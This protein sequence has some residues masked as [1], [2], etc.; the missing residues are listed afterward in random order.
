MG[1]LAEVV[2]FLAIAVL[3]AALASRLGVL[4]PI[5]LVVLGL[6]LSFVPGFPQF[7]LHPDLVLGGILPPL[8]YIAA[9]ETSVPAFRFNL[10]PI[11]L[12][13][14]G[15]VLF[16]AFAVGVVTHALLPAVP[17][18]ACLAFGAVVA[19]PDAVAATAVA[20]RVGLPR[21]VVTVLEGESL[22]NDAT[23]LVLLRVSSAAALG[24]AVNVGDIAAEAI[25]AAGGGI[26]VGAVGALII[27]ALHARII[28]PLLDNALSL[29]TPF[30]LAL[31]AEAVTA[32]SVV[33]V[34]V[35]GLALGHRKPVLLSAASRLQMSSFWKL[36]KFLLEG[37]VFLLV[38]LQLRDVVDQLDPPWTTVATV[39][40]AV[41]G[42]VLIARFIW[43]YPATYLV[44]LV[45]RVRRRDPNPPVAVPTVVGWAGMRGVVTLAGALALPLTLADGAAYPRALFVWAALAVIMTT[46]LI[47]GTTLP[48]VARLLR[49]PP[50]DSTREA[51]MR[52]AVQHEASRAARD[53]LAELDDKV[54][55]DVAE[56]LRRRVD[57]RANFAWEQI[58]GGPESP[59][60]A[61]ARV[62]QE[63]I[64][65]ERM[66]F[67]TAR[68]DGRIP[69]EALVRAYRDLDLEESLLRGGKP[70]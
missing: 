64:D 14:V 20:R 56:R 61:Y 33:A 58:G 29:L 68:D 23:A 1:A 4:S 8:L 15:L 62:R 69:E 67:R 34:V 28:D 42:T 25:V 10:R 24:A 26:L 17:F 35:A 63:M 22:V 40:A 70:R 60:E 47:Q 27:G 9:L 12:L 43:I 41:L 38:G 32:S 45:P 36:A 44:R 59:S 54:P 37:A 55:P 3:G 13:A 57:D 18:A 2:L 65:A 66:V 6:V 48:Y 16:T 49:L 51:L 52:A 53:R 30:I 31:V 50:D 11:L 5:L 21:R 46:L 7:Q 39:T 19:P